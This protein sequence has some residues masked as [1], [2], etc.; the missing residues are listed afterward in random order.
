MPQNKAIERP[1]PRERTQL[2]TAVLAALLQHEQGYGYDVTSRINRVRP[3]WAEVTRSRVYKT[4]EEFEEDG[5]AWSAKK[6]GPGIRGRPR[7]VFYPTALAEELRSA[8]I[9]EHPPLE[10]MRSD[11]RTWVAFA[12][13]R[14]APEVLRKL[15][16]YELDCLQVLEG[17]GEPE[18]EPRGWEDRAIN[19]LRYGTAEELNA[20]LKWVTRARREVKEHLTQ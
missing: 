19:V 1:R 20:E 8:W 14:D 12:R 6:Q 9:G 4:L 5:L 18:D 13:P 7:R 17:L 15:V 3:E 10:Q 11:I 2:R 16:E